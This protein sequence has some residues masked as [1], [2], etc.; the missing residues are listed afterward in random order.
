MKTRGTGSSQAL[1]IPVAWPAPVPSLDTA[2]HLQD[3][4]QN[5]RLTQN[6]DLLTV[7]LDLG[8]R[9]LAEKHLVA[10]DHADR[11]PLARVQ[12]LAGPNRQHLPPL[13]LLLR[14]IGKHN[15]ASRLFLGFNLLNHHTVLERTNR[16]LGHGVVSFVSLEFPR[17]FLPP[18]SSTNISSRHGRT[19]HH[20][21][22]TSSPYLPS[23]PCLP[24]RPY[25]PCLLH[26]DA[27]RDDRRLPS[28]WEAPRRGLRW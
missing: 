24:F 1:R 14:R 12:K 18:H 27:D 19:T 17:Q 3:L 4:G 16:L 20:N 6:L 25:H 13:R 7:D 21:P 22:I 10:L 23:H 2:T 26:R 8:A 11:S 28:S 5:V 9:I 15:P